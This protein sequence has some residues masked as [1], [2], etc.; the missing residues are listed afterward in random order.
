L[1]ELLEVFGRRQCKSCIE[2]NT[3]TEK[4]EDDRK[5]KSWPLS[6]QAEKDYAGRAGEFNLIDFQL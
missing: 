2:F 4:V 6:P 5:I 1:E 3:G